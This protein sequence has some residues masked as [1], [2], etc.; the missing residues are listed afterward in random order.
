MKHLLRKEFKLSA[1]ILSY[2]FISFG[3]MVFIP[4][5]PILIGV[6]FACLG[7]FQS[8]QTYRESNDIAYSVLL[9]VSKKE[10]V[11]A[12]YIFVCVIE[13]LTLLIMFMVTL[14][15]MTILKDVDVYVHNALITANF[16][17]M[18]YAFIIFGFFNLI[19][20][21]GFFKTAYYFAKPFIGFIVA[22]FLVIGLAETLRYVPGLEVLNSFG[23][24]HFPVQVAGL[25]IGLALYLI[26]TFIAYKRSVTYFQK[27]DL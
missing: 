21:R 2:L 11:K 15:R 23:F 18:G 5:Y 4:G 6:F 16:V 20:V 25:G 17:F 13:F 9:P 24:S 1:S 12:K 7:I 10:I 3:L 27:I 22:G 8:F 19:F 26:C 14:I